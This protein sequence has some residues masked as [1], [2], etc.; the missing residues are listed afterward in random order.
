MPSIAG[1]KKRWI[2]EDQQTFVLKTHFCKIVSVFD[3]IK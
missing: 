1:G 3:K 2:F